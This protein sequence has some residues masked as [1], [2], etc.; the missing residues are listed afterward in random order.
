MIDEKE[1][2]Y[3]LQHAE[4]EKV[5]R[6][7]KYMQKEAEFEV[8]ESQYIL[9]TG[10]N[11]NGLQCARKEEKCIR[12]EGEFVIKESQQ[13]LDTGGELNDLICSAGYTATIITMIMA[14]LSA[15]FS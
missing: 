2:G 13:I 9:D 5:S 14:T 10:G 8:K 7:E 15:I 4:K 6:E 12:G 1:E 3:G 11:L